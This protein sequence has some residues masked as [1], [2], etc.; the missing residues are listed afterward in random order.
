MVNQGV[1]NSAESLAA[2]SELGRGKFADR[3]DATGA[4][5]CVLSN[6]MDQFEKVRRTQHE[7]E[8]QKTAAM[9]RARRML[10]S[11]SSETS[12]VTEY[13]GSVLPAYLSRADTILGGN[14]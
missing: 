3:D 6:A 11:A 10:A 14:C 2:S 5:V 1:C 4:A 8:E 7:Y 9:L 12:C 13:V